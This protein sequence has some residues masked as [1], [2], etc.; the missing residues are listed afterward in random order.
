MNLVL[1]IAFI[2]SSLLAFAQQTNDELPA[3]FITRIPFKEYSGGVIILKAKFEEI[4]D[5]LNFILDSGSG[6]ASLDSLTCRE[7]NIASRLSDSTI[8]GIGGSKKVRFAFNRKLSFPGLEI[9][10]INFHVNDYSVLSSVYGEKIDG[11]IGYHFLK[12][13]IVEVNYDSSF[14][15]VYAPGS[16]KY[17]KG[18]Y[19]LKPIFTSIPI[20][21]A[22]IKDARQM[23]QHF[24]FD[25]GAG[26]C[27]LLSSKYV[28]DSSFLQGSRIPVPTQAEG[29]TGKVAM[30][31]TVIKQVKFGPFVFHKVPTYIYD[32]DDNVLSYPFVTGLLGSELLRRFNIVYN[33]PKK[34]IY[35]T[36]N[37]RINSNFDYSYTGMSIYVSD[38]KIQV[39]EIVKL[40]PADIC[41]F[42]VGD[43][44]VGV[45]KNFSGNI[46]TYK[47]LINIENAIVP[48][49]IR[50]GGKLSIIELKTGNIYNYG[51]KMKKIAR[52]RPKK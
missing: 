50:R 3:K 32:D 18:G 13:Y 19:L 49:L 52:K 33:Y 37:K 27:L 38:N 7:F 21:Y 42:K 20:Q 51:N 23:T 25:S 22:R 6:G 34:E 26:L 44:I 15:N 29:M 40:S 16:Y 39:E 46:N 43:E 9:D 28:A 36:P 14:L 41:G 10:S 8:A 24:Y 2:F 5:S 17:P 47:D 4:D 30:K 1:S 12:R 48:I 35:I 11:L 31:L 45:D